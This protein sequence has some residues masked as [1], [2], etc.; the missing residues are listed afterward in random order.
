MIRLF[1]GLL[2]ALLDYKV[3]IGTAVV[4]ILPDFVGFFLLMRGMESLADQS[5]CFDMG[6]HWAFGMSLL[7][8]VLFLGDLVNPEAMT[9]VWLW[10]AELGGLAVTLFVVKRILTGLKQMGKSGTEVL[11]SIWLILA[12]L[13]PLCHLLSWVPLVGNICN[14]A[15]I[16]AAGLFLIAFLRTIKKSPE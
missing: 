9:R 10:A 3:S 14:W 13:L 12:V 2:F 7:S 15:A 11:S 16:L 1:W 6:R 5:R 4:D 8:S